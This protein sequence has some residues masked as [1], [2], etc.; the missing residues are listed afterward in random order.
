MTGFPWN[1]TSDPPEI[2][3]VPQDASYMAKVESF[4][5]E[6]DQLRRPCSTTVSK[7]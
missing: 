6:F 2:T 3:G 4:E 1:Q 7:L 5:M